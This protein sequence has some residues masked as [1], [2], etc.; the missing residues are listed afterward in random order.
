MSTIRKR[1]SETLF[2]TPFCAQY[3]RLACMELKDIRMLM[4]AA[5]VIAARVALNPF[6][7]PIIPGVLEIKLSFWINAAGCMIYGPVVGALSGAVSD[8]LSCLL[9]PNGPYFFPFIFVEMLGS[10]LFGLVLYR[11][12]L[13]GA[14]VILSRIAVVVG[15]NFILN[16]LIMIPYYQIFFDNKAYTLYS[17]TLTIFKNLILLAPECLVLMIFLSAI[18]P[19]IK[20]FGLIAKSQPKLYLKKSHYIALAVLFVLSIALLVLILK[21]DFYVIV[22]E[23]LKVWFQ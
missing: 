9:F 3:W 18:V 13:S 15:C 16:P 4:L 11:A 7:I 6:A 22:R 8:S 14:R 23:Q 5:V 20:P 19:A 10:F 21:T 17:L 12:K 1:D 2:R